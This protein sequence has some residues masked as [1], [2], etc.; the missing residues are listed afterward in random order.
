M[1]RKPVKLV[2]SAFLAL[3][4]LGCLG[5]RPCAEWHF[6]PDFPAE[7]R[8]DVLTGISRWNAISTKD[9]YLGV[10]S[11]DTE[12]SFRVVSVQTAEYKAYAE[13]FHESINGHAAENG[14]QFFPENWQD[15]L[16]SDPHAS[17]TFVTMHEIAHVFGV[18]HAM[19]AGEDD[20]AIMGIV[21]PNPRTEYTDKDL[22]ECRRANA[23]E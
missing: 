16:A 20:P 3:T 4:L 17:Y 8:S 22:R 13:E 10:D 6:T 5:R 7:Y 14:I 21:N 18:Q 2:S 12:C 11:E 19:D 15:E 9:V 23:C 1:T